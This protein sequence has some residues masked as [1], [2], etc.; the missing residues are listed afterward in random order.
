[1]VYAWNMH[2]KCT[3]V[4]EATT[5]RGDSDSGC[6]CGN[7]SREGDSLS[8]SMRIAIF[9]SLWSNDTVE[10]D[11]HAKTA[12][13]GSRTTFAQDSGRAD[14]NLE[15]VQLQVRVDCDQ[16]H[17]AARVG[18]PAVGFKADPALFRQS[19]MWRRSHDSI[20]HGRGPCDKAW[21]GGHSR[22]ICNSALPPSPLPPDSLRALQL[23]TT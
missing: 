17:Q 10:A 19:D 11:L 16:Q 22:C 6:G 2:G 15:W 14:D 1:M 23:S 21:P 5:A 7:P 3:V 13:G 20:V 12:T 4:T 9:D 18:H 8:A